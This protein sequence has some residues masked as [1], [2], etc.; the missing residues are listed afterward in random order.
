MCYFAGTCK[1]DCYACSS[2]NGTDQFCEDPMAPA[3][4]KLD[5]H[6]LVPKPGHI[7]KF[8]AN[9]CVKMIGTS[10][11]DT[12]YE[13]MVFVVVYNFHYIY[14]LQATILISSKRNIKLFLVVDGEHLVVRTCVLED[15]ASGGVQC[16]T[17]RFQ[18]SNNTIADELKGCILTCDYDGCNSANTNNALQKYIIPT[19][20]ILMWFT[21]Y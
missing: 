16:G 5:Q 8:P 17:F 14:I 18:E 7:G 19:I 2:R 9:F 21:M 3:F 10:G 15:I 1:I 20:L 4:I 11:K 6:C 13:C 12:Y